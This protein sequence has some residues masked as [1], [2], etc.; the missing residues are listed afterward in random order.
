M[1]IILYG[2]KMRNKLLTAVTA[3]VLIIGILSGCIDLSFIAPKEPVTITFWS[4][5]DTSYF[6]NLTE[7]FSKEYPYITVE[8]ISGF[9]R[10][11]SNSSLE[12]IDMFLATQ[13]QLQFL[14][15]TEY[16][17]SLN[18]LIAEDDDFDLNDFYRGGVDAMSVEGQRWGV[19]LG[20]DITVM[21]YNKRLF[22]ER[23][24]PYP[25]V[26]WTWNDFLGKAI[27]LSDPDRGQFGYAYHAMGYMGDTDTLV[28]L[29][30]WGGGLFDDLQAPTAMT[31]NRPENVMALQFNA[32]LLHKYHVAPRY[33]ERPSP[34]P[35]AGIE[36]EKYAMWVGSISDEYDFETGVAPLPQAEYA[37]TMGTI[38]GIYI[39]NQA[40]SPEACWEWASF[41]SQKAIPG[42]LPM[43]ISLAES[44]EVLQ[45]LGEDVVSAGLASLPNLISLSIDFDSPLGSQWGTAMGAYSSALGKIRAGEPVQ[46]VLDE[47]QQKSGF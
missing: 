6:E 4:F 41:L 11:R 38:I 22:D 5:G 16:P 39:S 33:G 36:S 45:D 32:D 20:A 10:F 9:S 46:T 30:Q 37:Y 18:A 40:S 29:Y 2:N 47:A 17:M 34:Y 31:I 7:E 21:I 43:R 8:F 15:E 1:E 42:L 24:V 26:G 35:D 13:N 14:R 3:C 44:D 27:A 25:Q 19:P 28:M 12:D 23:N